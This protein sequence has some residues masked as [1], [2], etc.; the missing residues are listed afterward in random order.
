[1]LLRGL[2]L[3]CGLCAGLAHAEWALDASRSSL[4]LVSTKN[5][6]IAEVHHFT[7]MAGTL[8]DKGEVK[9][10]VKADSLVTHIDIRDQ[11]MKE[12]L[13][14]VAKFPVLE[15]SASVDVAQV[16]ALAIGGQMQ[17]EPEITVALHGAKKQYS[18]PLRITR[19][20]QGALQASTVAPLIVNLADFQLVDGVEHLRALAN[21]NSIATQLPVTVTMTFVPATR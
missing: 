19:L 10:E 16:N 13:L 6:A 9:I 1:M 17:L 7:A 4:H 3:I 8:S 20:H 5:A 14:E 12:H 18:V 15:I 11:R 21:L 2:V